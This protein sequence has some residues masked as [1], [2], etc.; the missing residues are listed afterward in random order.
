MKTFIAGLHI[1]TGKAAR[2]SGDIRVVVSAESPEDAEKKV[3]DLLDGLRH[4][5]ITSLEVFEPAEYAAPD[6]KEYQL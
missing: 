5:T 3:F 4:Q 6:P 2:R 1:H